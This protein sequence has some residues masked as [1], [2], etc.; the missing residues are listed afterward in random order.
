MRVYE[1]LAHVTNPNARF[2]GI[3]LNTSGLTASEAEALA[4][5]LEREHSLVV[6]DPMRFGLERG[7]DAILGSC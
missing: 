2:A 6:F 1:T 7:V 5:R 4:K 3:S